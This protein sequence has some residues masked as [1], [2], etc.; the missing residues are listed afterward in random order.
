MKRIHK[1]A[2]EIFCYSYDNY[3]DHL[4]INERFD[5]LM[6]ND[7]QIL[8]TAIEENWSIKKIEKQLGVTY[9]IATSLRKRAIKAIEIVD[10]ENPAESFKIAIKRSINNALREGLNDSK[11]IEA[12]VKE[13]SYNT[14]DLSINLRDKGHTLHQYSRHLRRDVD[15]EYYDGYFD[16]PFIN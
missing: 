5:K 2:A 4:G 14:A 1:L 6:P 8:E 13:I 16:E 15:G 3:I 11:S 12:L 9:E 7:A 10:A